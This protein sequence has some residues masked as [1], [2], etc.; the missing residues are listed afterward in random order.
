LKAEW[1]EKQ[2][3]K[4]KSESWLVASVDL[5]ASDVARFRANP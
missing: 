5:A 2:A 4:E 3:K 1:K